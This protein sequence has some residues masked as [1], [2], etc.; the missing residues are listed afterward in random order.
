MFRYFNCNGCHGSSGGGGMGPPLMDD[1]WI[2]GHRPEQVYLTIVQG[3]P[4]GMPSFGGRVADY[5]LWQLAAYVRSLS[6]QVPKDA[7]TGRSD[8]L[9]AGPPENSKDP[10]APK[11][12]SPSPSSEGRQ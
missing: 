2:Y 10:E 5:Q 12:S 4:N 7:A 11:A 3:R 8:H 1:Q 6:G 9:R